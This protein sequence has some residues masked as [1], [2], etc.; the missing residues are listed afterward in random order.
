MIGH[1]VDTALSGTDIPVLG[2]F[3]VTILILPL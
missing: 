2:M 1:P 3:V